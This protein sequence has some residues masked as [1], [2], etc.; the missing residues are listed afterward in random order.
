MQEPHSTFQLGG[1]FRRLPRVFLMVSGIILSVG[2][3]E[4]KPHNSCAASGL[5]PRLSGAADLFTL[6][7]PGFLC[8]TNLSFL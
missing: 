2:L 5:Q 6:A 3:C 7:K 1:R 8:Y 4:S